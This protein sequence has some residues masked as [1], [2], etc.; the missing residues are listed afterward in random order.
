MRLS[1]PR[2]L[3]SSI[4]VGWSP[5]SGIISQSSLIDASTGLIPRPSPPGLGMRQYSVATQ[6]MHA[7]ACT[8]CTTIQFT[9]HCADQMVWRD[10][11]MSFQRMFTPTSAFI[12]C[13]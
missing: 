13:M 10:N 8:Y 3:I 7:S 1:L 9:L 12:G 2:N 6:L 5:V 11:I 4:S